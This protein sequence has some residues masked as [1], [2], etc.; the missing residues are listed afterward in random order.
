MSGAPGHAVLTTPSTFTSN[1]IGMS[2][3]GAAPGLG[4]QSGGSL[5][6]GTISGNDGLVLP[7]S[8]PPGPTQAQPERLNVN[9]TAAEVS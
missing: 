6:S 4:P 7:P 5:F 9:S 2:I 8:I 1:P 3:G